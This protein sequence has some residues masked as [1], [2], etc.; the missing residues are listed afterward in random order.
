MSWL[1]GRRPNA[2]SKLRRMRNGLSQVLKKVRRNLPQELSPR[3]RRSNR[4]RSTGTRVSVEGNDNHNIRNKEQSYEEDAHYGAE[5]D[6]EQ[7]SVGR[8]SDSNHQENDSSH[9]EDNIAEDEEQGFVADKEQAG[10]VEGYDKQDPDADD[11]RT[12][13]ATTE[14]RSQGRKQARTQLRSQGIKQAGTTSWNKATRQIPGTTTTIPNNQ[15]GTTMM[16]SRKRPAIKE[17]EM[18]EDATSD[19]GS[20]GKLNEKESKRDET[21]EWTRLKFK[22]KKNEEILSR[23]KYIRSI[24]IALGGRESCKVIY[25]N[26]NGM[27]HDLRWCKLNEEE[28]DNEEQEEIIIK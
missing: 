19:L 10:L 12:K 8:D 15:G 18:K 17:K 6:G 4:R 16:M 26:N 22:I 27:M 21:S 24:E 5:D 7:G 3:P 23:Y 13:Q 28:E 9:K 1:L 11:D 14:L 2:K 20:V 25:H